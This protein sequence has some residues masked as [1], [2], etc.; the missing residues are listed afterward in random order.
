MGRGGRR[1]GAGRKPKLTVVPP[2]LE[3]GAAPVETG[4]IPDPSGLTAAERKVWERLAPLAR[5]RQTLTP[6]TAPGF[7]ILCQQW[8]LER[9]LAADTVE[10]GGPGHRGVVQRVQSLLKEFDLL[11][12]GK[13]HQAVG[14]TVKPKSVLEL[15]KE[16]RQAIRAV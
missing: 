4:S 14:G 11:P 3:G 13:P 1:A 8:V 5:E 2:V 12:N 7:E 15:L 10:R 16:R 6:A 9:A